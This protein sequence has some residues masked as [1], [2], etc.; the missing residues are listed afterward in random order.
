MKTTAF[1]WPWCSHWS[2]KA[3]SSVSALLA[4]SKQARSLDDEL[5]YEEKEKNQRCATGNNGVD[6]IAMRPQRDSK[7]PDS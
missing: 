6:A 3:G 2:N 7:R 4:F 1:P 5:S